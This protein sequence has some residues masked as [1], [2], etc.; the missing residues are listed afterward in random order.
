MKTLILT[1]VCLLLVIPCQAAEKQLKQSQ[2]IQEQLESQEKQ[3]KKIENY[4]IG[5]IAELRLRAA[6]EIRLLEVA[7]RPMP[8]WAGITEW[9]DFAKTVL[10]INGCEDE[11]YGL[12][13][14]KTE[15]PA[16]RLAV[17]LS[18][19]AERKNDILSK[20][21]WVALNLEKQKKYAL[22]VGFAKLEKRSKE[23]AITPKPKATH[24]LV[25]GIV[26]SSEKSSAVVDHK[27]VHE[28]DTIH[29]VAVVK[30]YKDKVEFEKNGKKWEQK[31][32]QTPEAYWK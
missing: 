30:I 6:A 11:P 28:R 10:E 31:V 12:F 27:I 1:L 19:I 2:Q 16:Q 22:T 21:K 32:Q 24:G 25:K 29:G 5:R 7:E 17:A 14:T 3:L 26:Y 8:A 23:N 18:R 9:V 20:S 15:T 13:E 4:F